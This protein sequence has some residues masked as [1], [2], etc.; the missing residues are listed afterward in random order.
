MLKK[1]ILTLFILFFS[2]NILLSRDV[3]VV[4]MLHPD[5][6]NYDIEILDSLYIS[7]W[8]DEISF[9]EEFEDESAKFTKISNEWQRLLNEMAKFVYNSEFRFIGR[10]PV[11]LNVYFDKDGYIDYVFYSSE[12]EKVEWWQLENLIKQFAQDFRCD[13]KCQTGFTQCGTLV[14]LR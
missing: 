14:L 8:N 12:I 13:L 4:N 1:L 3:V 7:L 11:F 2:V 6:N 5:Y 9:I 10:L